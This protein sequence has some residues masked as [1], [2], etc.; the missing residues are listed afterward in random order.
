MLQGRDMIIRAVRRWFQEEGFVEVQ[1]PVLINA[2]APEPSIETFRIPAAHTAP[3]S[4]GHRRDLFLIPSPELGMKRLIARG[5]E[6][7]FQI[8]PVFRREENGSLHL[9]EFTLLEW[10]R[11][12]A[13]YAALMDDCE[14]LLRVAAMSAGRDSDIPLPGGGTCC[15]SAPFP[16]ITVA[17]AFQKYAGWTPGP[18]PDPDRFNLDMA[19]KVEP[20]L[21]VDVPIFLMD[22]PASMASLAR[23]KPRDPSVAERVELFAGGME[24]ANGFSELTDSKEQAARFAEE[25]KKRAELGMQAYPWPE[26][27]LNDLVHMPPCAGMAMGIDRLVMLILKARDINEVT[28]LTPGA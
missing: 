11:T 10:Y 2:P 19:E 18:D 9:Q 14:A 4:E 7:I 12:G 16:R 5:M 20:G 3:D 27:F 15:L 28:A 23:L 8:G 22:Y 25:M 6:K 1:T 24:L 21:P 17:L 26:A 13:D